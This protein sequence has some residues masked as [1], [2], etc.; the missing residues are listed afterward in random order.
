MREILRFRERA[1]SDA[2]LIVAGYIY[3][4]RAMGWRVRISDLV[5]LL[6]RGA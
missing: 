2:E 1:L 4:A 5:L 3:M 6:R